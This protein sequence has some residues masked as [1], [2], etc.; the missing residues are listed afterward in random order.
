M[1]PLSRGHEGNGEGQ[2][3]RSIKT[4]KLMEIPRPSDDDAPMVD[5]G[6]SSRPTRPVKEQEINEM[7]GEPK[8]RFLTS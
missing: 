6:P 2:R 7:N 3:A 8:D 4:P 5:A 1:N